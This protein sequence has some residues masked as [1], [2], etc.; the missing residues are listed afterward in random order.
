[1]LRHGVVYYFPS[2]PVI[3]VRYGDRSTEQRIGK[4]LINK[5][6]RAMLPQGSSNPELMLNVPTDAKWR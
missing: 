2:P 6:K 4:R 1:M 5:E 3:L